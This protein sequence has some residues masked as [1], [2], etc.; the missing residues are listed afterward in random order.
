MATGP[1]HRG[2]WQA[3]GWDF[4]AGEQSVAWA[5]DEPQTKADA[6]EQLAELSSLCERKQRKLRERACAAAKRYVRR[7]ASAGIRGP[8]PKSFYVQTPPRKDEPRID[9][10]I[11]AGIAL[12]D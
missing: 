11:C 6:L 12:C 2:R 5:A 1:E 8:H 4:G 10:E 9:L 3:Q 7:A